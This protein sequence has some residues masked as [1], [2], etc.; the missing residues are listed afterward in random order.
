[1]NVRLGLKA[2]VKEGGKARQKRK[3]IQ[4]GYEGKRRGEQ[5]EETRIGRALMPPP[6]PPTPP[7]L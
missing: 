7:V 1:M 4:R 3:R 2:G 5:G 6:P